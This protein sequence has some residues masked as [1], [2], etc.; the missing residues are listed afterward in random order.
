MTGT[1][2][3]RRVFRS[4]RGMIIISVIPA[5]LFAAGAAMTYRERGWTWLSAGLA[6]ATVFG[7]AAIVE[8]LIIR[9][10]LTDDALIATDLRGRRRYPAADIVRVGEAKGVPTSIG[11][12]D[13]RWVSLPSVGSSLGNSIRAWLKHN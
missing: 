8:S 5:V 10:E 1:Y 6:C 4:G 12:A 13:G 2:R 3:G 9:V 11:L 7:V